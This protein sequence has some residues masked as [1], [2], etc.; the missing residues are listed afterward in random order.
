MKRKLIYITIF[1][2]VV[3]I[4]LAN[5]VEANVQSRSGT[6][7]YP[8]S[9]D[10]L[11]LNIRKMESSGQVLGLSAEVDA[12]GNESSSNNIDVH[13][14]KQ[15]EMG[16]V[17]T[18]INSQYG[19]GYNS[20][21]KRSASD[22]YNNYT[23]NFSST[24]NTTG[25]YGIGSYWTGQQ[26]ATSYYILLSATLS[27]LSG[28]NQATFMKHKDFKNRYIDTYLS[29]SRKAGDFSEYMTSNTHGSGIYYFNNTSKGYTF[30]S[31]MMYQ[32]YAVI[33]NGTGV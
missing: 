29:N 20:I 33:V 23:S 14:A 4:I 15:T 1:L 8:G 28:T 30:Y 12:A 18:F 27:P 9:A 2:L 11:F 16:I 3:S 19:V 7:I 13:L 17:I 10:Y 21:Q 32:A 5:Q 6:T 31:G 26:V 25:I 22:I 24:K